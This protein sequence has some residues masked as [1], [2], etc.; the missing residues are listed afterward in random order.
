MCI[1]YVITNYSEFTKLV[2]SIWNMTR[3][4]GTRGREMLQAFQK[5]DIMCTSQYFKYIEVQ[6]INTGI[7]AYN[8]LRC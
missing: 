5:V 6:V 4:I 7:N 3:T 2:L 8:S 1:P